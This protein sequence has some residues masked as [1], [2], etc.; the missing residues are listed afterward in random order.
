MSERKAAQLSNYL[1][2][3]EKQIIRYAT[4][5]LEIKMYDEEIKNDISVMKKDFENRT[6]IMQAIVD[7]KDGEKEVLR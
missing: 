1:S 6:N 4:E 7:G 5:N 3:C 2:D